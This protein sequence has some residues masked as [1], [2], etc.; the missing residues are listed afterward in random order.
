[1]KNE[2]VFELGTGRK[3]DQEKLEEIERFNELLAN[4]PVQLKVKELDNYTY[5]FLKFDDEGK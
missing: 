2:I 4:T 5:I 1:M 3:L